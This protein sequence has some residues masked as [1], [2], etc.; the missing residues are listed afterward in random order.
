MDGLWMLE[1]ESS[2]VFEART[3]SLLV[4][5]SEPGAPLGQRAMARGSE[6][7]VVIAPARKREKLNHGLTG[8]NTDFRGGNEEN[9]NITESL[10]QNRRERRKQRGVGYP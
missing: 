9:E 2:P 5:P 7:A 8:M 10:E 3:I 4:F 1:T 6:A